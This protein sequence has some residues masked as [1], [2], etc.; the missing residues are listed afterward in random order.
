M[1]VTSGTLGFDE[2]ELHTY[3]LSIEFPT[4]FNDASYEGIIEYIQITVNASQ[5]TG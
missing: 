4:T 5:I 3:T 2:D 1:T